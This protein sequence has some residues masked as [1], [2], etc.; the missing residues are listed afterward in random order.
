MTEPGVAE[1]GRKRGG[2]SSSDDDS[3]SGRDGL[4][5]SSGP[6]RATKRTKGGE[7]SSRIRNS[8]S[9]H[10]LL[11]SEHDGGRIYI[12]GQFSPTLTSLGAALA[13]VFGYDLNVPSS[14]E[15]TNN[16]GIND[17]K[18]IV[19]QLIMSTVMD[20]SHGPD[21]A[22]EL[23]HR[24]M[25]GLAT[26][27]GGRAAVS[28]ESCPP[29][30]E[31]EAL[32]DGRCGDLVGIG[33]KALATKFQERYPGEKTYPCVLE[34]LP[35]VLGKIGSHW[36]DDL[37][38][39]PR[40]VMDVLKRGGYLDLKR[41]DVELWYREVT[42]YKTLAAASEDA[43][44]AQVE[45]ALCMCSLEQRWRA[46]KDKTAASGTT[47]D[48]ASSKILL[49]LKA[50]PGDE[51]ASA[52]GDCPYAQYVRIALEEKGV[53]YVLKPCTLYNKPL[54]LVQ[55]YGG[56]LPAISHGTEQYVES[57]I[58]AQY[59]D[60]FFSQSSLT[61]HEMEDIRAA[62]EAS[63]GIFP[64]LGRYLTHTPDHDE[65]AE[66]YRADLE[67][68]LGRLEQYLASRHG[69][70]DG[71]AGPYLVGDGR[72]FSLVDASLAPKLYHMHIGLQWFKDISTKDMAGRFP[73][74]YRYMKAV[75]TR[76]SVKKTM[77]KSTV[78]VWGWTNARSSNE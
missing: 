23:L 35:L 49:Y 21:I 48:V 22:G 63:C 20:A 15:A 37:V 34:D 1:G 47:E 12:S 55:Q 10:S 62:K 45:T 42:C 65:V 27:T 57:E 67:K 43:D 68:A 19:G 72:Q 52:I 75:F 13:P 18:V 30:L 38:P 5:P 33:A 39:V 61:P 69:S 8:Q 71:E 24:L 14:A 64:S 77:P 26:A 25:F 4:F 3:D 58:C 54:W 46:L 41:T 59:I 36:S 78:V 56:A 31:S 9:G 11:L 53:P 16:I 40:R 76:P 50:G 7:S 2:S 28:S 73:L 17:L 51:G 6:D 70:G 29:C 74:V 32:S 66:K 60:F 44:V